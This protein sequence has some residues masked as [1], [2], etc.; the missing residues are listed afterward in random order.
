MPSPKII[1]ILS[2]PRSGSS[3]TTRIINL[4][5]VHIGTSQ[6]IDKSNK[7][8]QKGFWEH[9]GIQ[10]INN[11]VMSRLGYNCLHHGA[12]WTKPPTFPDNWET[13]SQFS[14]LRNVPII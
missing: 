10:D 7:H 13:D 2:P 8:N 12:D 5:G 1:C 3:L 9:K 11:E 14:D 4:L 6:N